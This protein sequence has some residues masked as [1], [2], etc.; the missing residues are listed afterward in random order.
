MLRKMWRALMAQLNKLSNWFRSR[1]PIAEMQLE[2]DRATD[3]MREGRQG[4]ER[5]RALVERV[6]RQVAEG[7]RHLEGLRAKVMTHLQTGRRD[8]AGQFALELQRG[9]FQLQ[10]N[11]AQLRLHEESYGNNLLKVKHASEKITQV[12]NKITQYDADLKMSRTEAEITKLAGSLDFDVTTDFGQVEQIIQDRIDGN[13]A[14]VRVAADLSGQG[15]EQIRQEQA[16]E[17]RK[18][19]QALLEFEHGAPIPDQKENV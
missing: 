15:V 19:E 2:C 12:R 4:L 13:R 16:I 1:D 6:T 9:E 7:E 14:V 17:L 5:Q 8:T 11:R 18:A 3:Q 10:E